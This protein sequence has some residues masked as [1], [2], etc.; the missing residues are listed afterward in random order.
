MGAITPN[1]PNLVAEV[2]RHHQQQ[3]IGAHRLPHRGSGI[4]FSDN[5]SP[6]HSPTTRQR[7]EQSGRAALGRETPRCPDRRRLTRAGQHFSRQ[8]RRAGQPRVRCTD[9]R[10]SGAAGEFPCDDCSAPQPGASWSLID[11]Q[12]TLAGATLPPSKRCRALLG[13]PSPLN[14]TTWLASTVATRG[15]HRDPPLEWG[16]VGRRP[17]DPCQRLCR[18]RCHYRRRLAK[19]RPNKI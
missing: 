12:A 14:L 9:C 3:V 4:Q 16:T 1:Q 18:D 17:L 5:L 10:I 19:A 11:V 15:V 7:D 13:E 6:K 8:P 2:G